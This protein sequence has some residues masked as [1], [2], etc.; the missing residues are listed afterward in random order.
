VQEAF[1]AALERWPVEGLPQNPAGWIVTTA[2]NRAIDRLRRDRTLARKTEL[3]GA[4]ERDA[5]EGGADAPIPDERL[6]LVFGCC[7]PALA[8]DLQVALTLR[9]VGGLTTEE[10]A[11]AFL[12]P[13]PT[14]A[15]RLVR[16]KRRL[17]ELDAPF[18]VPPD[19]ELPE[20]LGA[21]LAVLYLIFNEGYGPPP[22]DDLCDEAIRLAKILS[23]LMPDEPEAFGLL[24]LML[25]HD[26]RRGARTG[27]D[28]SLVLLEDQDR[29]LWD[30]DRISEGWRM[31]ERAARHRRP[32]PYQLQAAIAGAHAQEAPDWSL[33]ASLYG[34]LAQ[35]TPSPVV[36]L[37]RAV[38]VA[39]DEGPERGLELLAEIEGLERYHL[40][41]AARAD[42]LRRLERRAEAEQAYRRALELADSPPERAFLELRLAELAGQP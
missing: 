40:L 14:M 26:S 11:A 12:V 9:S 4:L 30:G 24:A 32:G 10:I 31:L 1:A 7:H 16:A 39:M 28:G 41:H 25:F 36:E 19:H 29:A 13:E 27:T 42:L 35:V 18:A 5:R 34:R 23:V 38:A 2:R 21:V 17:R 6:A 33:V 22:R 15:Q 8:L 37:N 20:R 3:L